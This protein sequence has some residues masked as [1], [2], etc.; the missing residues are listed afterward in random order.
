MFPAKPQ[1]PAQPEH[2]VITSVLLAVMRFVLKAKFGPPVSEL[3]NVP[4]GA[5]VILGAVMGS[6]DATVVPLSVRC[7]VLHELEPE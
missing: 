4:P 1:M 7:P 5:T 3:P 2:G 6:L